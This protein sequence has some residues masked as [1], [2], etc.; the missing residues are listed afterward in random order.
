[1]CTFKNLEENWKTLKNFE[2]KSGNSEIKLR[3]GNKL[4]K[5]IGLIKIKDLFF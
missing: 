1:M 5:K 3:V 2:K 4:N